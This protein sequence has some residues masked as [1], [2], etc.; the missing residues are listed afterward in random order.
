MCQHVH[1]YGFFLF[2]TG[3]MGKPLVQS[4]RFLSSKSDF[5]CTNLN[6]TL[7]TIFI[8]FH[9]SRNFLVIPMLIFKFLNSHRDHFH[10]SKTTC[11][12]G[13]FSYSW[14]LLCSLLMIKQ[15]GHWTTLI[16]IMSLSAVQFAWTINNSSK[17]SHYSNAWSKTFQ[18]EKQD[19]D[20]II[21]NTNV[22][23]SYYSVHMPHF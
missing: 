12:W 2:L 13:C 17:F 15:G 11:Q 14:L 3:L 5:L 23:N 21:E 16:I 18:L 10:E 4:L 1:D 8:V 9:A 22:I 6:V 20:N 19:H 7:I